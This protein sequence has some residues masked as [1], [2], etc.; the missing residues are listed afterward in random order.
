[1][2]QAV[3]RTLMK[4]NFKNNIIIFSIILIISFSVSIASARDNRPSIVDLI[5]AVEYENNLI[6]SPDIKIN[7]EVENGKGGE[8]KITPFVNMENNPEDTDGVYQ[9]SLTV[10]GNQASKEGSNDFLK[11]PVLIILA[12]TSLIL[13]AMVCIK[14]KKK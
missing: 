5:N 14:F 9:D 1:M 8:E 7:K 12:I 13:L 10:L 6:I 3:D 11:Q 4:K 2:V